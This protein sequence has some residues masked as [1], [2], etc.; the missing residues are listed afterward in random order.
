VKGAP[1]S[2]LEAVHNDIGHPQNTC[3]PLEDEYP[4]G[5]VVTGSLMIVAITSAE[6]TAPWKNSQRPIWKRITILNAEAREIH[7]QVSK[8]PPPLRRPEV[9]NRAQRYISYFKSLVT[10]VFIG[11]EDGPR[12]SKDTSIRLGYD[13]RY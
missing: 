1:H 12:D 7:E 13:M 10:H 4:G 6:P 11:H 5:G 2:E 8:F 3:W 9:L